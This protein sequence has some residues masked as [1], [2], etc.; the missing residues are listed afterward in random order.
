MV[1]KSNTSISRRHFLKASAGLTS[2]S[3]FGAL[4]GCN[5]EPNTLLIGGYQTSGK[6]YGVGAI[7]VNGN[8]QWQLK[9]PERVHGPCID[10][11]LNLGAVA[12]RRPGN[13]IQVFSAE[14]GSLVEQIP[15]PEGVFFEGHVE[16]SADR[17]WA[18]AAKETTCEALLLS[19]QLDQFTSPPD[20]LSLP[21]IGPHQVLNHA[22]GLWL[23]IGGWITDDRRV[24]NAGNF[25]SF[26]LEIDPYSGQINTLDNPSPGLSLRHLAARGDAIYAGMQY[27][28]P[29]PSAQPLVYRHKN[30]NWSALAEPQRGWE[31]FDGYIA[32][33]AVNQSQIMA[34]SP[35]GHHVGLWDRI[36]LESLETE[37]I[38]DVSAAISADNQL[39][40]ASG[41]GVMMDA[42]NLSRRIPTEFHWDNH[43][44]SYTPS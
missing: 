9:A 41:V 4:Q 27:A 40:A 1:T 18:T 17:L 36:T 34:T 28:E 38:L 21:G 32:S 22:G 35:Q 31:I 44:I 29:R 16:F 33:V 10:A 37:K 3:L 14:S 23:A 26:L 25:E 2:T 13:F 12:A 24:T 15:R 11:K 20:I 6:N 39:I 42:K 30:R 7:D 8:T 5:L 43:W 19:W